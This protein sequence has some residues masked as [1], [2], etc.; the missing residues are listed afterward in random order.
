MFSN[1][2]CRVIFI[3]LWNFKTS[4]IIYG[5]PVFLSIQRTTICMWIILLKDFL[6]SSWLLLERFWLTSTGDFINCYWY[7]RNV[8]STKRG[9][10]LLRSPSKDVRAIKLTS[11]PENLYSKSWILSSLENWFLVASLIHYNKPKLSGPSSFKNSWI[12]LQIANS[13]HDEIIIIFYF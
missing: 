11:C 1:Q 9:N 5:H 6:A 4:Q 2:F 13:I 8:F 3:F 12:I 7:L 10:F